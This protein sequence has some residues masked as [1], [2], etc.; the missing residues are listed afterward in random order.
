MLV[1]LSKLVDLTKLLRT[2]ACLSFAM[3]VAVA[4]VIGSAFAAEAPSV[5]Q[6]IEALKPKHLTRS[7]DL[8]APPPEPAT[9]AQDTQFLKSLRNRATRSLTL[10]EREKIATIAQ[11]KPG[12]DLDEITFEYNSAKLAPS[13]MTTARHLGEALTSADL[14]GNTF[15]IEGYTDSKGGAEFNQKLSERRAG[16]VKRFLVAEYK[17][18]ATD[19]VAVGYGKSRLKNPSDPFAAEN[20]RVRVVN[21]AANVANK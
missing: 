7:L 16:A 8:G 10:A 12:L 19:L 5:N 9:N 2:L 20:R 3:G 21:M 1:N 6:I 13:A 11:D 18:P 14:K 17:I 4:T 15:I